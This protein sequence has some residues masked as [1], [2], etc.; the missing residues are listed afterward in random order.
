MHTRAAL[1]AL[2]KENILSFSEI[3]EPPH[4]FVVLHVTTF[5]LVASDLF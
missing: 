3:A 2:E 4:R 1:D 5:G